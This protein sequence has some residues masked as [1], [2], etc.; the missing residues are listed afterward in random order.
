VNEPAPPR[1]GD[2]K[3]GRLWREADG[4][5]RTVGFLVTRTCTHWDT[6]GPH[7]FPAHVNP[8]PRVQWRMH[9]DQD[10]PGAVPFEDVYSDDAAAPALDLE[11]QPASVVVHGVELAVEWLDDPDADAAWSVHGW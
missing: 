11:G 1:R 3:V 2:E 5:A 9:L 10:V 6:V 4:T 7:A 8:E